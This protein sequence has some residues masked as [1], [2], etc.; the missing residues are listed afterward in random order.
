MANSVRHRALSGYIRAGSL[1]LTLDTRRL[2]LHRLELRTGHTESCVC[3]RSVWSVLSVTEKFERHDQVTGGDLGKRFHTRRG[4]W[5][6]DSK[7]GCASLRLCSSTTRLLVLMDES[8]ISATEE[9]SLGLV[10]CTKGSRALNERSH[11]G[12]MDRTG[13]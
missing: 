11:C 4:A 7:C 10:W 6:A 5:M 9:E 1:E 12:C 13:R 2:S 3:P 8:Y